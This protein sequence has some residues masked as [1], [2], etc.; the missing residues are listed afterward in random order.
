MKKEFE[1]KNQEQVTITTPQPAT[2]STVREVPEDILKKL[3]E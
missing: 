2:S 3:L 1:N